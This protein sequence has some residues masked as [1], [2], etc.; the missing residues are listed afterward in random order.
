MTTSWSVSAATDRVDLDSTGRAEATFTV[1]NQSPTD[2]RLVFDVEPGETA[3]RAWFD[4]VEPQ[5]LVQHGGS[6]TF[7]V[8]LVVPAGTPVGRC[9]FAGRAYSADHAPEETS[10]VSDRVAFEVRPSSRPVPWWRKWWWVF[11]VAAL[12]MVAIAVVLA[13][14]LRDDDSLVLHRSGQLVVNMGGTADLDEVLVGGA[15]TEVD[16]DLRPGGGS[17]EWYITPANAAKMAQ[18][19]AAAEP[20]TACATA[21]L[22]EDGIPNFGLVADDVICVRTSEGRQSVVTVLGPIGLGTTQ[23]R[24]SVTTYES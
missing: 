15:S 7:L 19:G 13:F 11:V 3:D 10:V 17:G 18:I 22:S 20:V 23:L 8:R 9:W 5:V 21:T 6:A 1:T 24:I 14:V 16:F 4:V 12:L 2:Q